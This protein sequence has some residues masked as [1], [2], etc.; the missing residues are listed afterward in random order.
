MLSGVA[1]PL[2]ELYKCEGRN[3]VS[4]LDQ[5]IAECAR[6]VH[7]LGIKTSMPLEQLEGHLRDDVEQR[8]KSGLSE[9]DAFE[10]AVDSVRVIERLFVLGPSSRLSEGIV[11]FA[12]AARWKSYL[13]HEN[14]PPLSSPTE[15]KSFLLAKRVSPDEVQA[16]FSLE[17]WDPEMED[18][19]FP[20][21]L[22]WRIYFR[23]VHGIEA[24]VP[25][26]FR[27]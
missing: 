4:E 23:D 20:E 7:A 10:A 27:P 18:S 6:H 24:E 26:D 5:A 9:R 14:Q 11:G 13:Q 8:M 21:V 22:T 15:V 16:T 17:Y 2:L 12:D 1:S 3:S 25:A 19:L